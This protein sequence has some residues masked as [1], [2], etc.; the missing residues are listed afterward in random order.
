MGC[1]KHPCL[2]FA[3]RLGQIGRADTCIVQK[4]RCLPSSSMK[5]PVTR[6]NIRVT[7]L[8]YARHV[9][10]HVISY[11]NPMSLC[12]VAAIHHNFRKPFPRKSGASANDRRFADGYVFQ[13]LEVRKLSPCGGYGS[14]AADFVRT[15]GGLAVAEA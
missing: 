11:T 10:E 14:S 4:S 2:F 12:S 1:G 5:R 6:E 8:I 9:S 13:V 15:N 3:H 7:G